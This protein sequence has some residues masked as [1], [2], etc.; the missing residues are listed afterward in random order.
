[1][2]AAV[3]LREDHSGE[4]RH[5]SVARAPTWSA[6][7]VW[8]AEWARRSRC[9]APTPRRRNCIPIGFRLIDVEGP[10]NL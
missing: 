8:R 7:F 3:K 1:M 4:A 9:S 2:S 10:R 5:P 6:P